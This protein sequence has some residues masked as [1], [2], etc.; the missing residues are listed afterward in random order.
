M[1]R[2]REEARRAGRGRLQTRDLESLAGKLPASQ[3]GPGFRKKEVCR[4]AGGRWSVRLRVPRLS[5]WGGRSA[6]RGGWCWGARRLGCGSGELPSAKRATQGAGSRAL[7]EGAASRQR[8]LV[9]PGFALRRLRE[10]HLP[11]PPPAFRQWQLRSPCPSHPRSLLSGATAV[12]GPRKALGCSA[13]WVEIQLL[14][15]DPVRPADL[16]GESEFASF[17]RT[18]PTLRME[19]SAAIGV[20]LLHP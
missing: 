9:L 18:S 4:C 12:P 8:S 15:C 3:R 7:A 1:Q 10:S 13:G 17:P 14:T 20:S 11:P 5:P 2:G 19:S 6:T 16:N